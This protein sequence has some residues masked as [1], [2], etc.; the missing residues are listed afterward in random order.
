MAF[1][2]PSNPTHSVSLYSTRKDFCLVQGMQR[3]IVN[4]METGNKEHGYNCE[5][6]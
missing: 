5:G 6:N 4:Y 3:Q 2:V 1:K